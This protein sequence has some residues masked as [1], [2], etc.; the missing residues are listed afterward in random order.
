MSHPIRSRAA[1]RLAL[2]AVASLALGTAACSSAA[3]VDAITAPPPS[4][5]TTPVERTSDGLQQ[6]VVITPAR[7]AT[8]DT[9]G[10]RSVLVNRGTAPVRVEH[11]VCGLDYETGRDQLLA[12]PFVHCAAYSITSTL[13]PGDSVVQHDRRVVAAP[14]GSYT[15][16]VRH[17]VPPH[18]LYVD[19]P[20]TV[21]R[22]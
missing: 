6:R 10:I 9:I 3:S 2:G 15:V 17:V 5:S 4:L 22:R 20:L 12:N 18:D 1:R 16:R 11:V 8:G 13:A 14:A 19:V 21:Q 7:P